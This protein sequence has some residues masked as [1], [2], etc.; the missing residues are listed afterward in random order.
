M[1]IS[2]KKDV[3]GELM[4]SALAGDAGAY[5]ALLAELAQAIRAQVRASLARSGRG[6]ADVEDIV[7]EVLL[8]VHLKRSTWDANLAFA[9]W[10]NT[11]ARYKII[12]AFRREGGRSYVQVDDLQVEL[13]APASNESDIGDAERL[14]GQLNDRSQQIVRAISLNGESFAQVADRLKMKEGAVRVA[15]HRALAELATLYR[16]RS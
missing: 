12:D 15:L 6:N 14:I 8:A 9:P 13:A 4:R 3:W 1:M 7:Q 2:V 10:V 11:I 5:K 16:Q